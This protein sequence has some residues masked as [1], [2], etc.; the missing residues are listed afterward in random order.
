MHTQ[1]RIK[2]EYV[3]W[4]KRP[5]GMIDRAVSPDYKKP[6]KEVKIIAK[7]KKGEK[8][9]NKKPT[10]RTVYKI[11]N[12]V[13]G[14]K[15]KLNQRD[16][17]RVKTEDGIMTV[18]Q[19][20]KLYSIPRHIIYKHVCIYKS[21]TLEGID[22][23]VLRINKCSVYKDNVLVAKDISRQ[24]ASRITGLSLS[25]ISQ[26]ISEYKV[27]KGGYNVIKKDITRWEQK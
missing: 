11:T 17:M 15:K 10:N 9:A 2:R 20:V 14:E 16:E 25:R 5:N 7:K 19:F 24:E 23:E 3:H 26:L 22:I 1:R 18:N 4:S 13:M 27:A 6:E 21:F 12:R 8:I